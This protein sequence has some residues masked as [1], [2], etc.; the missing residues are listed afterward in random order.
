MA[1]GLLTI[2]LT[3]PGCASLKEK[4]GRIK[5]LLVRLHKEFNIS[6]AEVDQLD[7]WQDSTIACV[8]VSN[9]QSHNH[10][11]LQQVVHWIEST[12]PD[13]DVIDDHLELL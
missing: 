2:F 3:F 6:V 5:P 13:V 9:D 11:S 10:R 4:R 1:V 8:M 7:S 12:W